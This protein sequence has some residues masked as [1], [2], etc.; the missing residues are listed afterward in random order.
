M[1][2][3][4]ILS[5]LIILASLSGCKYKNESL[6]LHKQNQV[7]TTQL[8]KSDSMSNVYRSTLKDIE[9]VF[10][11]I[12][13]VDDALNATPAEKKLTI[14]LTDKL[15]KIN[16]LLLEKEKN[17]KA[18]NYRLF[19]SNKKISEVSAK[20]EELNREVAVK[21]SVNV[22]LNQNVNKLEKQIEDQSSQIESVIQEKQQLNE[23]LETKTNTINS[24]HF[25]A[26]SEDE[27]RNKA[28]IEK[29]G[30]FLGFLGRVNTLNPELDKNHLQ[31]IDIRE[32]T[33]FS[34]N[35]EK[36]KIEFITSHN[37]A[38]YELNESSAE[39]SLLTITNPAEFWRYSKYLVI[40]Y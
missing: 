3:L 7:L 29:T 32:K 25:I 40:T 21:D 30:G 39:T 23:A 34:L 36:K 19:N 1:K 6:E 4:A 18:L 15:V 11:S 2:T 24:T 35:A 9:T 14:K 13:P 22:N 10:D 38:S 26:G 16:D 8:A 5:A 20:M 33:T 31:L 28:I 27:L 37:P 12:I 17:N